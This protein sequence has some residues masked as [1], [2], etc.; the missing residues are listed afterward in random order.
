VFA[1]LAATNELPILN[2]HICNFEARTGN[3]IA[4]A[5]H[6]FCCRSLYLSEKV[7][8]LSSGQAHPALTPS[9]R[10]LRRAAWKANPD[11]ADWSVWTALETYLELQERFGWNVYE[12]VIELTT[13]LLD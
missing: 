6:A 3:S 8:G 13:H 9:E 11:P 5:Y 10:A 2:Q 4:H 7:A 12:K 1:S